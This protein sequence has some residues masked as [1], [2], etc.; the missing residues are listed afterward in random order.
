LDKR[1]DSRTTILTRRQWEVIRYRG[2]GLTQAE[3]ARE[4]GTTKE[5]VSETEDRALL[6]IRAAKATLAALQDI[7]VTGEMLIPS[8]T[9]IFEAVAMMITRADI[10][11]VKLSSPGDAI[12]AAIRSKWKTKIRGHRLVSA[13]T[14]KIGTDGSLSLK[15]TRAA[16]S[17]RGAPVNR[18]SRR[19]R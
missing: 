8:G 6:K 9:S 16:S 1:L 14:A 15:T 11:G 3:V 12:L 7:S 5:E 13:V 2:Q 18:E 17:R 10:L 19:P 4:L